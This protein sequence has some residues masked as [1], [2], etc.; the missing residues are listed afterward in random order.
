MGDRPRHSRAG[1]PTQQGDQTEQADDG[2]GQK[3]PHAQEYQDQQYA[4]PY[5]P[6]VNGLH[7]QILY[8]RHNQRPLSSMPVSSMLMDSEI[9]RAASPLTFWIRGIATGSRVGSAAM[10]K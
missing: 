9:S 7:L 8:Q 3:N 10:R 2:G 4:G 5:E 1:F 6:R